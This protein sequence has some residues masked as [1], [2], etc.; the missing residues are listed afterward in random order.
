MNQDERYAVLIEKAERSVDAAE[1]AYIEAVG[2]LYRVGRRVVCD[3]GRAPFRAE[4]T[5]VCEGHYR[6][7]LLVRN[8]RT[9]KTRRV[10]LSCVRLDD[11]SKE[12]Q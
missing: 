2:R 5:G 8:V 6:G 4:V 11:T 9:G 3:H 7:S 12:R 1:N 10:G